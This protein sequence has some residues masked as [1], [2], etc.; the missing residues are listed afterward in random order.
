MPMSAAR[1]DTTKR[2]SAHAQ[3]RSA[4]RDQ[5]ARIESELDLLSDN[6][7]RER[8]RAVL[9]AFLGFYAPLEERLT[10]RDFALASSVPFPLC[11]RAPA[12]R[13]DLIALGAAP[14]ELGAIPRCPYVPA[15]ETVPQ[16]A[17]C[18][19]VIEGASLG[20]QIVARAVSRR[21]GYR[22]DNGAGFF[23][24]A[25]PRTRWPRVLAWLETVAA[26]EPDREAT[27]AAARAAFDAL[28]RWA[29]SRVE[30]A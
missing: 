4:T 27:V 17:G 22:R 2:S 24:S 28:S 1:A 20:G 3:L 26:R 10:A 21:F 19:Y 13:A 12:L 11:E 7:S 18:L 30:A 16:L 6:L 23:A 8:Y 5:H 14:H 25:S 29:R 15:I 9:G